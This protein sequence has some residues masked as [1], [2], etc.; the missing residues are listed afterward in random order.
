MAITQ[1][2]TEAIWLRFLSEML[3]RKKLAS[4]IIF[5]DNQSSIAYAHNPEYHA[6]TKHIH[7]QH[8]FVRV[9]VEQGNVTFEYSYGGR[10][11]DKDSA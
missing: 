8:H 4:I 1:S 10:L 7:I 11:S 2:T 3:D 5:A 9:K 6:R